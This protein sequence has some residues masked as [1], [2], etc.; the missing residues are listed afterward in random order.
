VSHLS[1]PQRHL[2]GQLDGNPK[3]HINVV[4]LR[5]GKQLDESKV[6]QGKQGACVVKEKEKSPTLEELDVISKDM[7]QGKHEEVARPRV[8]DPN[9]PRS[10]SPNMLQRPSLRPTLENSWRCSKSYK[11]T[12]YPWMPSPRCPPI[13]NFLRRFFPISRSFKS[14]L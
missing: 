8:V 5:I 13:P 11:S 9:N 3:G 7:E 14:M 6:T 1:R 2:S 12:S 10:L 4:I